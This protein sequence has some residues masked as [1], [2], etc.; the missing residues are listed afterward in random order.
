MLCLGLALVSGLTG[1]RARSTADHTTPAVP[2]SVVGTGSGPGSSMSS[3]MS[4][5]LSSGSGSVGQ[6]DVDH[7]NGILSSVGGAVTSMRSAI[8]GDSSGPR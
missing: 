8:A 3:S 5:G 4:S 6:Q 2:T 7:L 1:C